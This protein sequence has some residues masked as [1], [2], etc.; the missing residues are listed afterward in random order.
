MTKMSAMRISAMNAEQKLLDQRTKFLD[1]EG[2]NLE[3][4]EVFFHF[5]SGQVL[6]KEQLDFIEKLR[7]IKEKERI[8]R[9]N[10]EKRK[11]DEL[12]RKREAERIAR[13]NMEK[14]MASGKYTFDDN[15]NMLHIHPVKIEK[16]P[17]DLNKPTTKQRLIS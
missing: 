10:E 12:H 16:L 6:S 14:K 3:Q 9:E 11:K 2:V 17:P 1:F 7:G 8:K 5:N 15:G 13:E 4:T